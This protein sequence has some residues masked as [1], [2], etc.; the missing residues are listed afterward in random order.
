MLISCSRTAATRSALGRGLP[1][2]IRSH[3]RPS[4]ISVPP[5]FLLRG[6]SKTT[7]LQRTRY[8]CSNTAQTTP[9]KADHE[10]ASREQGVSEYDVIVVGGG[11][12]GASAAAAVAGRGLRTLLIDQF[13]PGHDQGSSHGDGR[14]YRMAYRERVYIDMMKLAL[15]GWD[16][17]QNDTGCVLR[18]VTGGL[19]IAEKDSPELSQL[20][21]TFRDNDID[22]EVLSREQVAARFPQF[23][24]EEGHEA[25]FQKDAGVMFATK[26]TQAL[27]TWARQRGCETLTGQRVVH[28]TDN[29]AA[30]GAQN[31]S[32]VQDT[33]TSDDGR[34]V[35][36]RLV[37]K[38]DAGNQFSCVRVI[39]APGPWLSQLCQCI[40]VSPQG[41][42]GAQFDGT[43]LNIP[44]RVSLETVSYWVPK[45]GSTVDHTFRN[46][47]VFIPWIKNKLGPYGYYGLPQIDIPGV[48]A[49]AHYCGPTI[50]PDDKAARTRSMQRNDEVQ[51]ATRELMS[52]MFPHLDTENGP[53]S[54]VKCL[55]TITSDHDFVLGLHPS[56]SQ[57][58]FLGGGSGH[59]FKFGPALG[60]L[61]ACRV[62][63]LDAPAG[64]PYPFPWEKFAPERLSSEGEHTDDASMK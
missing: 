53:S 32:N 18:A 9:D 4:T 11:V 64:F 35:V 57:L 23:Q 38:T 6:N 30:L 34:K 40:D 5:A 28:I 36:P 62:L 37:V 1:Y 14:I 21:T 51:E 15:K 61:A 22:F 13:E 8:F 3:L 19:D 52:K 54:S 56:C 42:D 33:C 24:L 10:G 50:D 41:R 12:M 16:D 44:T 46:M 45:S 20:A 29:D 25:I 26:S 2:H 63:G 47:P 48:K 59:G 27:W 31:K 60:E 7:T 39:A 49:S 17:V 55:Y 43:R 58:C